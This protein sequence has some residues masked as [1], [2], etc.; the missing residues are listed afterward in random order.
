MRTVPL[1]LLTSSL[2][3]QDPAAATRVPREPSVG[4]TFKTAPTATEPMPAV[5][6]PQ[7]PPQTTEAH[8]QMPDHLRRAVTAAARIT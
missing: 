5:I 1:L 6:T 3:A 2:L 8:R 7:L 4:D